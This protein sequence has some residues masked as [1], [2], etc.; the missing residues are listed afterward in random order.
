MSCGSEIF[1]STKIIVERSEEHPDQFSCLIRHEFSSRN[2]MTAFPFSLNPEMYNELCSAILFKTYL[3]DMK[4][5]SI[6]RNLNPKQIFSRGK[7]SRF[8]ANQTHLLMLS[9]KILDQ[10]RPQ[11]TQHSMHDIAVTGFNKKKMRTG[12]ALVSCDTYRSG[13]C[14]SISTYASERTLCIHFSRLWR[15]YLRL[16]FRFHQRIDS[17]FSVGCVNIWNNLATEVRNEQNVETGI[18]RKV[19]LSLWMCV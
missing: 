6:S 15:T 16:A 14:S 12:G 10:I 7:C 18:I 8:A 9:T 11:G 4:L 17:A 19:R 1:R 2:K 3:C 5:S 13:L